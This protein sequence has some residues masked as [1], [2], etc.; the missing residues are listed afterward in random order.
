MQNWQVYRFLQNWQP[1]KILA[2]LQAY[3]F[4][5]IGRLRE[6]NADNMGLMLLFHCK[7]IKYR[8]RKSQLQNILQI[9]QSCLRPKRCELANELNLPENTIKV[10][11]THFKMKMATNDVDWRDEWGLIKQSAGTLLQSTAVF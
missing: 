11:E 2:I 7:T 10:F 4:L 5:Q 9:N 3:R 6:D 8:M 1:L